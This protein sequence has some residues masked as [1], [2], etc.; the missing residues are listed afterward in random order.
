MKPSLFLLMTISSVIFVGCQ[1]RTQEEKLIGSND[2]NNTQ[3]ISI[4]K[5]H[6]NVDK[7]EIHP[8]GKLIIQTKDKKPLPWSEIKD[9]IKD[10]WQV[11]VESE[12]IFQTHKGQPVSHDNFVKR[13]RFHDLRHT[14]ATLMAGS[15]IDL[16]TV[17]EVCSHE[18]IKTTMNYAHL[19]AERI[20]DAARSFVIASISAA[21]HS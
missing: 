16:R 5:T 10:I 20:R 17:Q 13:I 14:G 6:P 4:L 18:N 7:V 21:N 3:I 2:Q 19:L 15:G 12:T 8:G 1:M 11:Q 9:A